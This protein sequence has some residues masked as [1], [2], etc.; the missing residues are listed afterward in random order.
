MGQ[1]SVFQ[2]YVLY[3][4]NTGT[5]ENPNWEPIGKINQIMFKPKQTIWTKIQSVL[6]RIK[7]I[8]LNIWNRW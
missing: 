3:Y 2:K 8:V 7:R 1:E 4:I 6:R 5:E